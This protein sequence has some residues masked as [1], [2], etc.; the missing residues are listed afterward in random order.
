ME[1]TAED[2]FVKI[3]SGTDIY[4][5]KAKGEGSGDEDLMSSD[6][7]LPEQARMSSALAGTRSSPR[8]QPL[9]IST[10][11]MGL[12]ATSSSI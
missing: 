8:V 6:F 11:N 1:D 5:L 9:N 7:E 3:V 10:I 2:T 12:E 4:A